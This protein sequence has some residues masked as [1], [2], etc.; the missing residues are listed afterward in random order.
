[1]E[2]QRLSSYDEIPYTDNCFL[3]THPDYLVTIG[4]LYGLDVPS[5][6]GCRLLELGCAG[7]GNV[8]PMAQE[9]PSGTFVGVDL[10]ARQIETAKAIAAAAGLTNVT[11]HA[12]NLSDVDD[13]FGTFDFI[14]CHGVYS[15]VPQAIRERILAVIAE[16]LAPGGVAYV[17]YN[18]Y[19]G[20]HARGL[21]RELLAYHVARMEGVPPLE[22]VAGA[23]AFLGELARDLPIQDSSYARILRSEDTLLK[24]VADSYLFHEHLEETNHPVYFHEFAARAAAHALAYLAETRTPGLSETLNPAAAASLDR[25]AGDEDQG[26]PLA[27]EQY[28]DFLCDRTF[29]RSLLVHAAAHP[30]LVRDG[31][32]RALTN[33]A[34]VENF[35]ITGVLTPVSDRPDP[36]SDEPEAFRRAD[37]EAQLTTNN[38]VIKS[39][40]LELARE[41]PHPIS[42]TELWTRVCGHLDQRPDGFPDR[43]L[44]R[45][46]LRGAMASCFLS[47][48]VEFHTRPP[49]FATTVSD[50]PEASPLARTQAASHL[51]KIATL[52]RRNALLDDFDRLIL[53]FLDGRH[54]REDLVRELSAAAVAGVFSIDRGDRPVTDSDEINTAL[55]SRIEPALIRLAELRLLR[56]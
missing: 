32:P 34:V 15:W 25:W 14:I 7:G 46:M 23:R 45:T 50:R 24:E 36:S 48:L 33:P 29:R 38:P 44:A 13:S 30:G 27:R 21:V 1:M 8:L 47:H 40:L 5:L 2:T 4:A 39:A 51:D 56:A 31:V 19:P 43:E 53:R 28:L 37:T 35:W 6:D 20:W 9:N 26:D 3:D 12:L 42:F 17:S 41:R 11:F 16:R 52:H 18:T 55:R 10:S 22:R 54:D 49:R